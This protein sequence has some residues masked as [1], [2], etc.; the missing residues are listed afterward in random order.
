MIVGG[1]SALGVKLKADSLAA[2]CV[3]HIQHV[4][5]ESHSSCPVLGCA[6][7]C[8]CN[9]CP[10]PGGGVAGAKAADFSHNQLAALPPS[11][12]QL[13]S[14]ASL[15]LSHN[16]LQDAGIPWPQLC[17]ALS[18]S[19]STL[20]LG[21]NQLQQLPASVAQLTSLT[22]LGVEGNRLFEIEAGALEGLTRLEVLQLQDNQL[23]QLPDGLGAL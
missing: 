18:S 22:H 23:Q 4:Q 21:H 7:W 9:L 14:L 5:R 11:L 6:V 2:P 15:K 3:S 16:C 1:S 13:T 10:N 12:C 20:Q 19:L 8:L 17:S